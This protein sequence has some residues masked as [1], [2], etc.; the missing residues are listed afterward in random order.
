MT[1]KTVDAEAGTI[2][3]S[4]ES[5]D[6]IQ[7]DMSKLSPEI[8]AKLAIHGASQKLGDSY[9]GA[10][11]ACEGSEIDPADYARGQ[12]NGVIEQLI[13]GD[14]TVRTGAGGPAV[15]DLAKA[16]AEATGNNEDEWAER[17]ADATADEKKELRKHPAVKAAMD[18]YRAERAA[19]KAAQSA[20]VE[21]EVPLPQL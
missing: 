18:R 21:S 10:K 5:G 3:F 15:T 19:A 9:A 20:A 14:W 2:N 7:F 4:F 13:A 16:L 1:K 11:K 8:I 12:V 17:L 6:D